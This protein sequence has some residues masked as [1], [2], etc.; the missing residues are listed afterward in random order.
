L[1]TL[2]ALFRP[3]FTRPTFARFVALLCGL[4]AM[5]VRRTV[6]GM[7][8]GTGLAGKIH[9]SWAHS[10]FAEARWSVDRVSVVLSGLVIERLVPAGAPVVIAVDDT[11]FRRSGRKVHAAGWFHDGSAKGP[12]G[13][14]VSWGN[15]WVIAA[16]VVDLPFLDRPMALPVAFALCRKEEHHSK[17]AIAARLVK[18]IVEGCP[19]RFFHVVGDAWYSGM[20]GAAGAT[21]DKARRQRGLPTGVTLT[22]RLRVNATLHALAAPRPGRPG[23][24]KVKG[25][26]IGSPTDLAKHQQWTTKTVRRY[27]RTD[28][29]SVLE[30]TCLWYNV[31]RSRTVRVILIRDPKARTGYDLA[32]ITTDLN[33]PAQD[34]IT[35]YAS[36]WSIEVAIEDAKQITGVGEAR[37]RVTNAVERT[38]PFG[39]ITQSIVIAWYALHGHTPDTVTQRREQAPWY[40]TKKNPSYLDMIVKLRRVLIAAKFRA[41]SPHEPTDAQKTA[42]AAAWEEAAA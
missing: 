19:E 2:L 7:L 6:C 39:L 24:P 18:L 13:S 1:Y 5:P 4:V 3:C 42:I 15:N 28:T 27:G 8:V 26:P 17:Q 31:Y 10:F 40:T 36:R 32:L 9:H 35:R 22:S 25:D 37:N 14:Q 20:D 12:R 23:R 38:V 33:S 30:T 11:L 34:I 29:V 21:Q 16:I 41:G